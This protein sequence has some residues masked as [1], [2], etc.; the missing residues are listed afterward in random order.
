MNDRLNGTDAGRAIRAAMSVTLAFTAMVLSSRE[1]VRAQSGPTPLVEVSVL[2]SQLDNPDFSIRE[3]AMLELAGRGPEAFDTLARSY[4]SATPEQR[5][6]ILNILSR[7]AVSGGE[8]VF[9]KAASLL[10]TL[11]YERYDDVVIASLHRQWQAGRSD[12]AAGR[13]AEAG[14]IVS[15]GADSFPAEF[16]EDRFGL[17]MAQQAMLRVIDQPEPF[18]VQLDGESAESPVE[19]S[20]GAETVLQLTAAERQALVER[21]LTA[22]IDEQRRVATRREIRG[23]TAAGAQ[24]ED[25]QSADRQFQVQGGVV[26]NLGGVAF[27]DEQRWIG[28]PEARSVVFGPQWRGDADQMSDLSSIEQLFLVRFDSLPAVTAEQLRVVARSPSVSALSLINTP[29]AAVA[30]EALPEL[31]SVTLLEL[32]L[33]Q[34][35]SSWLEA[36]RK[37]PGLGQ[38]RLRAGQLMPANLAGIENV[39]SLRHLMLEN[40]E[41]TA[42]DFALLETLPFLVSLN[43]KCCRFDVAEY[44]AFSSR[45]SQLDATTTGNSFLGVRG[46]SLIGDLEGGGC[47]ISETVPGSAA[48]SAGVLPGDLI[49][50][51]DGVEIRVFTDLTLVISQRQPGDSITLQ[52][53]REGKTIKLSAVLGDRKD[54]PVR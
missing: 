27:V 8:D 44:R 9:F 15:M 6:R 31:E 25:L 1:L 26:I 3:A 18:Q 41:L 52:I 2:I 21:L 34:V 16:L 51:I 39:H 45:A 5:W 28:A 4:F 23:P 43:L 14:A 22:D 29:V 19:S 10:R 12:R 38:L 54:A 33:D 7:L 46:P 17:R 35:D 32:D 20:S 47:Q 49:L 11:G 40:L 37:M 42:H 48:E 36:A 24:V 50:A 13:L 30:L 53:S